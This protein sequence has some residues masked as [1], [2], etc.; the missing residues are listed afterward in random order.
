MRNNRRVINDRSVNQTD[1]GNDPS[2][3]PEFPN[4]G[5]EKLYLLK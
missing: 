1:R 5:D 2:I 3:G 4:N